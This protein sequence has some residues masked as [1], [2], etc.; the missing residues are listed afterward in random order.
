VWLY[1]GL[2]EQGRQ[3]GVGTVIFADQRPR[4]P[5]FNYFGENTIRPLLTAGLVGM[6]AA[7]ILAVLIS[8]SVARPLRKIA[9]AAHAIAQGDYTQQA[10][11]A[12][13]RE[14]RG[15][16]HAFNQ[17]AAQVQASQKTQRDFLA[18]VSHELKTPLTSIQGFAQAILDGA[19][20]DPTRA[21]RVIYDEAGHMRR[22]VEDLLD[23]ARIESGQIVMQRQHVDLAAVLH[24]VAERLS[25]RAA[26]TQV[27]L[28]TEIAALP[29]LTGD[30]DRLA[31]VFSNLVDNA[32]THTPP[33][34]QVMIQATQAD[35]MAQVAV[36][37][38]GP[39]IPEDDLSRVFERFYQVDKSRARGGRQG[40]GLGLA[41][42]KE[43]VEAHGGRLRAE[44]VKGQGATFR[45]WL[46]LPRPDDTTVGRGL[47]P[48]R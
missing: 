9:Q 44:S 41:I 30:G 32:L 40:A 13:P 10:P 15:V 4:L 28:T 1:V 46:P 38:T 20:G 8:N 47:R 24:T 11:E 33:G 34:G 29:R 6:I 36:S 2:T 42:S 12:G 3:G 31:Q 39:G 18:N 45:V 26:E 16:A 43:I 25:L 21:A 5:I 27:A 35:G 7:L 22:I 14:V 19:A 37:D 48:K 23:L 17:M